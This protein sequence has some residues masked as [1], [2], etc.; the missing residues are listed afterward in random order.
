[1]RWTVRPGDGST[2]GEVLARAGADADAVREGRVFLGRLRVRTGDERVKPGDDLDVAPRRAPPGAN[3]SVTFLARE[4]DLVAVDKPAGIPTIPDHAGA[5]HSL[6]A[7][8]AHAL[9]LEPARV[10]PTSRL[11]RDVSGVVVFA[12]SR[13]AG[14]RLMK[15]RAEGRYER[16]YVALA[17]RAPAPERGVWDVP[18]GRARDPRLRMV[19]GRDAVPASTRYA[20]AAVAPTR[21]ALLALS[22]VTGRT[23]Q[24]RVHASHAGAPLL[25]D[26]AYGGPTRVTL[27]GGRVLE[28]GRIALH[29]ARVVVPREGGQSA[30]PLVLSAPVPAE[31]A[32]L[33]SALG[34]ELAAWEVSL[35][36][37]LSA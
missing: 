12:L 26:R 7:R 31:L 32:S 18:I 20:V 9:G 4:G 5:S 36:C 10:H 37:D 8:V 17:Q 15:A 13:A 3:E 22:P 21:V 34:G 35:A 11:D 2:V 24:I 14:E 19:K 6:L 16:R 33:W 23:H 28:P 30:G 29:A 25:G 27:P 1:L